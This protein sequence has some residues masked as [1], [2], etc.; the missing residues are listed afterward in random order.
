MAEKM[1]VEKAAGI[2]GQG[3]HCSQCVLIHAAEDLGL[4]AD[5]AL[6][7]SA[8]LGGGCFYGGT[9][10][11]VTGAVIT[12][13]LAYGYSTPEGAKV[14]NPI[15]MQK[16][17]EFNRRFEERHGSITCAELLGG[18]SFAKPEDM[19][20]IAEQ[21]LTHNCPALCADACDIL[22]DMLHADGIL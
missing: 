22:D 1:T 7:L 21:K 14:Q 3:F 9:C 4:D 13:G 12:L 6:K 19:K 10:G 11:A 18:H 2:L 8:G 16:V 5:A 20:V 17:Q 15:L